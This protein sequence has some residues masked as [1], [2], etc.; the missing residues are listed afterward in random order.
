M[1]YAD[2]NALLS[3]AVQLSAEDTESLRRLGKL[4]RVYYDALHNPPDGVI[5][6]GAIT[7]AEQKLIDHQMETHNG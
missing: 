5:G 6:V 2:R 3:A 7:Y 1:I 4:F